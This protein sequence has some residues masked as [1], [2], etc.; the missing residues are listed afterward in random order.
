MLLVTAEE[1]NRLPPS[2][3]ARWFRSRCRTSSVVVDQ[4]V[5]QALAAIKLRGAPRATI[6]TD[7]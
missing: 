3:A 2:V 6:L 1:V 4:P 7:R 5:G